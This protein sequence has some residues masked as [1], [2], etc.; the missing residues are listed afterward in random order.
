MQ[1]ID[2]DTIRLEMAK[3]DAI[4]DAGLLEPTDVIKVKNISYG[5]HDTEN[6]LDL[7]YPEN[8]LTPLPVIVSIHGGGFFYGDKELYRFYT[9]RLAQ[10]GFAVVN[11]NYRLAPT[12]KYPAPLE[13]TNAVMNW[14]V[15]NQEKYPLNL[16][17]L[18]VV[19]DSAGGQLTEQ[20]ATINSNP[21]Y[22]ALFSFSAA[23]VAIKGVGLNCGA[24]FIG[25]EA[26]LNADF[27]FYFGEKLTPSI[28][29]QFPVEQFITADFPS[30][31]VTSA[32]HDFLKDVA[33]PLANLLK[34]KN[35]QTECKI[36]ADPDGGELS[37]V[38]HVNQK[39]AI[40]ETCNQA[41]TDFFKKMIN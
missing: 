36:Y 24:Y 31:F 14:L 5:P 40:A 32:T 33:E 22:A 13:D 41:Q 20:Y 30:A 29:K 15:E 38:F 25:Q 26:P 34:E 18:F 6:L 9:M 4:R 2:V 19:G 28:T 7:Y 1:K 39:L 35:V 11:F 8:T 10:M 27:P 37:H 3:G 17:Q 12:H 21:K 16:D 23:P